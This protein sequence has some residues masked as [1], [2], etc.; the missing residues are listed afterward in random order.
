MTRVTE[1][2]VDIRFPIIGDLM[3]MF[4]VDVLRKSLDH[5]HEMFRDCI[6]RR[7]ERK[8]KDPGF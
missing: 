8:Q 1:G 3:E 6:K 7:I 2:S 4:V 5:E